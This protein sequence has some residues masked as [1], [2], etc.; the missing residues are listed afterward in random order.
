MGVEQAPTAK[1]KQSARGLRKSAAKEEKKV[2]AQKGSDLAKG[3]DRF[4]ERSKSSDGR[5]A[6]TKQK[7]KR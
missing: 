5:S 2:E 3:A 6:G 7:P 1:G 4:E